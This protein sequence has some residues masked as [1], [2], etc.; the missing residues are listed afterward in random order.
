[1]IEYFKDKSLMVFDDQVYCAH[2]HQYS[3][4]EAHVLFM[5]GMSRYFKTTSFCSRGIPASKPA[6]YRIPQKIKICLF[7]YY[8]NLNELCL[9]L[10]AH[11]VRLWRILG[12]EAHQWDLALLSW[13]HPISML[14]LMFLKR[15]KPNAVPV[16][17]V[18]QNMKKLVR[19]RYSGATRIAAIATVAVLE[20]LLKFWA[21]R[22]LI[23]AVGSETYNEMRTTYPFVNLVALPIVSETDLGRARTPTLGAV[24]R[25]LF[26]G[27]VEPEKGL[28]ILIQSLAEVKARGLQVHLDIVGSGS[29][30]QNLKGLIREAGLN[31]N[32]TLCGYLPYGEALFARYLAADMFVL[33]SLSEG[34]PKVLFEAIAFGL[35]VVAT[36]VGGIT[37]LIK[38]KANGLLVPPGSATALSNAITELINNRE[39][40][41]AI[42]KQ[43]RTN[44]DNYTMERQQEK[45]LT[46][47]AAYLEQ[48]GLVH[49][50]IVGIS[51]QAKLGEGGFQ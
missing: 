11:S 7:P 22:T 3:S 41:D 37:A 18:R 19:M 31:D 48:E 14:I 6:F 15:H 20:W 28:P 24:H 16:L 39:L 12:K 5:I 4:D 29:E 46:A 38:D 10:P 30:E 2:D 34:M 21:R 33:P 27:R 23:L 45:M 49:R 36:N 47:I 8:K 42:A 35:P 17:L 25:L 51:R 32:V 1:M 13:P 44:V 43:A 40:A 26:V 9:K 50:R